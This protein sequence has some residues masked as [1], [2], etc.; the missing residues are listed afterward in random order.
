M[1]KY[2]EIT[3]TDPP[4]P[5]AYKACHSHKHL[6]L[7]SNFSQTD[8]D[9]TSCLSGKY[10]HQMRSVKS[11]QRALDESTKPA[12]NSAAHT[13]LQTINQ[14]DLRFQS[15]LLGISDSFDVWSQK[16]DA[17]FLQILNHVEVFAVT[18]INEAFLSDLSAFLSQ[19]LLLFDNNANKSVKLDECNREWIYSRI[20]FLCYLRQYC[21]PI[22]LLFDP[23]ALVQDTN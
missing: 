23:A 10:V 11:K 7:R 18:G 8:E 6:C 14:L 22:C 19:G 9:T 1:R 13:V 3:L 15:S 16:W 12:H 4:G 20:R 21:L 17:L 2:P 5:V